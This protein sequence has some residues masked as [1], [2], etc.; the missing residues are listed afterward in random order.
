[1]LQSVG[2]KLL[3]PASVFF[4]RACHLGINSIT[5]LCKMLPKVFDNVLAEIMAIDVIHKM[6]DLKLN[7]GDI[8]YLL[9]DTRRFKG[10]SG[11]FSLI[12][13]PSLLQAILLEQDE[14]KCIHGN[15]MRNALKYGKSGENITK[16]LCLPI[17][18][19]LALL[20]SAQIG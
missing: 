16:H 17:L 2:R 4:I 19:T 7:R 15:A 5:E 3:S 8:K 12:S 10:R 6:Y 14:F 11:W 20:K 9:S 13:I 1:M 18:L